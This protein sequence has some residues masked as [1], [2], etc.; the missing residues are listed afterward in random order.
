MYERKGHEGEDILNE[1]ARM[2]SKIRRVE[3]K[4]K[5]ALA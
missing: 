1:N 2:T 3:I 4:K 5:C